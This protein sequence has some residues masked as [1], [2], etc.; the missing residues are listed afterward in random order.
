MTG[1]AAAGS[2]VRL[3]RMFGFLSFFHT[4]RPA[5]RPD[6]CGAGRSLVREEADSGG[7]DA[8]PVQALIQ[9]GS[10]LPGVRW[11]FGLAVIAGRGPGSAAFPARGAPV[12]PR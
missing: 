3:L 4:F 10:A 11:A 8:A 7:G 5:R 1:R 12:T 9:T 6:D 2:L